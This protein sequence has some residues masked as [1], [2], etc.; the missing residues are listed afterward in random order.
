MKPAIETRNLTKEFNGLVAVNRVNLEI[1]E[2]EL[3]GLLGPNGAGKTTLIHMLATILSP[4]AGKARVA[5]LDIQK[6]TDKVRAA[7]GIVFQDPSLD[8]RL[9]GLENLDFHGRM[10]GMSKARREERINEALELVGLKERANDLVQKYSG[11]MK[12]RLEMARGLIHH[13]KILFLDEPTLGLDPQTRRSIWDYVQK[14]NEEEKITM[15]LTTHYIEEADYLCDRV[16]IID[17]GKIVALGRPEA[18]KDKLK[19][20]IVSLR[21]SEPKRFLQVLQK[22]GLVRGAKIAG[23]DLHLQVGNGGRALPKLIDIVR[24]HG[25]QVQEARLSRPTLEDVFIKYTGR[26]IREEEPES[27]ARLMLGTRARGWR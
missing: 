16:G 26:L 10:Y 1:K 23:E 25:G 5:G 21:V 15:I 22:S 18:L 4:T 27:G 6:D 14:L 12:R 13:P 8:N 17:H 9:T 19:G 20:D 3:F 2:G 11:G 7:I 24:A